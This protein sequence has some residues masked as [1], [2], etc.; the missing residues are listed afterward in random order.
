MNSEVILEELKAKKKPKITKAAQKIIQ[1]PEN[2]EWN[3]ECSACGTQRKVP[4]S[5]PIGS[6]P[7]TWT[8]EDSNWGK[9]KIKC[10]KKRKRIER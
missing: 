5:I 2:K 4:G 10:R 6:L 8:C 9:R 1:S 7:L 3:I